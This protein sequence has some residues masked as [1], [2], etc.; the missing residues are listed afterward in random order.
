[1]KVSDYVKNGLNNFVE[2]RPE[3]YESLGSA[4]EGIHRIEIY[5]KRAGNKIIDAKFNASKRCKKLLAVAD[6]ITEQLKGQ[7]IGKINVHPEEILE[8]FA[9]EKDKE[10]MKNRISIVLKALE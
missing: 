2:E 7:E 9:E 4:K 5:V 8:F 1:L 6:V 10:K 3:N